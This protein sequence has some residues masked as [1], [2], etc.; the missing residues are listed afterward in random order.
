MEDDLPVIVAEHHVVEPD[1]APE[2]YQGAVR[3]FPGPG[4]GIVIR[5]GQGAVGVFF[6]PFQRHLAL[7]HLRLRLHDFKDPLRA[8]HGGENG[9]HLLGDLGDGLAYLLGI[10]QKGRQPAQVATADG[11]QTAH[12][13]GNGVVDVAQVSHGRHHSARIGLGLCGRVPVG[14]VQS[15]KAGFG[16]IL[17]VK[18]LNDLLALDHL[19]DIAVHRADGLLLGGKVPAAAAADGLDHQQ[20][21][22]QHGKGDGRQDGA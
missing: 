13:A 20:H 22:C 1:I 16:G 5:L 21:H 17:V 10:L 6:Y 14:L 2:G 15:G 18:D 12:A 4:A 3:L 9:V 19:L 7:V 8:G 11:Q